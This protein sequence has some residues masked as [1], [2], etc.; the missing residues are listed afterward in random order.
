[1]NDLIKDITPSEL[2]Q[3]SARITDGVGNIIEQ[4]KR[5]IAVYLNSEVSMTYWKIGKY[6]AGE[7]DAI[8]EDKYGSKIA[9]T[10]SHQL[11]W[12]HFVELI[13]I[14]DP[15]KRLFYQQMSILYHWIFSSTIAAFTGCWP[16]TLNW[17]N[18]SLSIRARWN[19]TSSI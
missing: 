17:V 11:T 7:L 6:I 14:S 19:S 18:S 10:L 5:T 2:Q 3:I 4:S 13:A 12:S 16:S 8:G 1:M 9:A 15:T